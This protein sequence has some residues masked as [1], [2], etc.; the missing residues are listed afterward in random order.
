MERA[1]QAN[2][3]LSTAEKSEEETMVTAE[4]KTLERKTLCIH[5]ISES[6]TGNTIHGTNE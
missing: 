6:K 1:I 2:V 5:L 4:L 3:N